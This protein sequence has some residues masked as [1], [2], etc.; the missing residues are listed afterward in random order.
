MI[1]FCSADAFSCVAEGQIWAK[2]EQ[3]GF[4]LEALAGTPKSRSMREYCVSR[5]ASVGLRVCVSDGLSNGE[6]T[7]RLGLSVHA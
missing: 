6:V 3:L 5:R 2:S 7:P 1:Q 4:V